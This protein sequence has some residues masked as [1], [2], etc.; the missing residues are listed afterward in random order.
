MTAEK[1]TAAEIVADQI[2]SMIHDPSGVPSWRK[3]WTPPPGPRA[4]INA[5]TE[6]PYRGGN[7]IVMALG[8]FEGQPSLFA[9]FNQ[10][11]AI[12]E[13]ESLNL[14][15]KKGEKST[16]I[17]IPIF[18][19]DEDR[20]DENS[21]PLA[22]GEPRKKLVGTKLAFG[23]HIFQTQEGEAFFER[24]YGSTPPP[25]W[26]IDTIWP[27]LKSR[28]EEV[29]NLKIIASNQACYDPN[30]HEIFM[31]KPGQFESPGEFYA[32]VLHELT[33][34]TEKMDEAFQKSIRDNKLTGKDE[35]AYCELRAEL[36]SL[37]LAQTMGLPMET[38]NSASY[39]EG[40]GL[41]H[42]AENHK[43]M[44][45]QAANHAQNAVD[46]IC[47]PEFMLALQEARNNSITQDNYIPY[48]VMNTATERLEIYDPK[49][50][51][52]IQDYTGVAQTHHQGVVGFAWVS[53]KPDQEGQYHALQSD[54]AEK[55]ILEAQAL[56]KT[57]DLSITP[58]DLEAGKRYTFTADPGHG[59][60]VVPI[61]DI[62]DLGIAQDITPFSY[63][64]PR[65][66]KAYLEEDV[67]A[68]RF[69]AAYAKHYG[70]DE[71]DLWKKIAVTHNID[72]QATY[73]SYAPFELA[74]VNMDRQI[75]K[76]PSFIRDQ[77]FDAKTLPSNLSFSTGMT[78]P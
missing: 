18:K 56:Q 41:R 35:N 4:P 21:E 76:E 44:I 9:T 27:P 12:G 5:L 40:W 1:Q 17:L 19:K 14:F 57:P 28:I 60:L 69:V 67:D 23:F 53:V 20:L 47:T 7:A 10:W 73:R 2:I 46:I 74:A 32:T 30:T 43:K 24:Q 62:V 65:G 55:A 42:F 68:P 15:V 71:N 54:T 66:S 25:K 51:H 29:V 64:S 6:K 75:D 16:P 36:G 13:R 72:R 26:D 45:L 78:K 31:P 61:R 37:L 33:H 63:L 77:T 70:L 38:T 49:D 8:R 3:P 50:A 59:W 48:A 52:L 22:G 11:K 58:A 34:A 39:I